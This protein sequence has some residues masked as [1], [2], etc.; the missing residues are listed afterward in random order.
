MKGRMPHKLRG[1]KSQSY[2]R[3]CVFVDT[4]TTGKKL[5]SS[6]TEQV[7][8]L[9]V[10]QFR[11]YRYKKP[12]EQLIF[13]DLQTYWNWMISKAKPGER[14]YCVA[15]NQDF[16]F[17]ILKGLTF[18]SE[19]KFYM[20]TMIWESGR[21]IVI[22]SENPP[23]FLREKY[24]DNYTYKKHARTIVFI[25]TLNFFKMSLKQLGQIIG[26][27]KQEIN[28]SEC[29]EDQLIEYCIQDVNVLRTAFENYINYLENHDFGNFGLTIAKQAFNCF[30]H[31]Y[32]HSDLYVHTNPKAINLERQA[33]YGGR[34]ECFQIGKIEGDTYYKLDI[35]SMYPYVMKNYQYPTKL[36]LR[37]YI[38]DQE[39]LHNWMKNY[40]V[41]ANVSFKTDINA[42][43]YRGKNKLLF[44]IGHITT[45]LCQPELELLH[46]YN[47]SYK[48]NEI[49]VY[50]KDSIFTQFVDG[51]YNLRL[52]SKKQSNRQYEQ[53]TK[54]IMNSLYGKFGQRTPNWD[55]TNYTNTKESWYKNIVDA[56]TGKN[57]T[58]KSVGGVVFTFDGWKEGYDTMVAIPA[59][60]TSYARVMLWNLIE[61]AGIDNVYYCDTDSLFVNNEGLENL[62]SS[63]DA[64]KLGYLKIEDECSQFEIH[65]VK[66]YI[67]N[68][69]IKI[70]GVSKKAV[71]V[72]E[73]RYKVEHWEHLN[74]AVHKDR[75][76]SVVIIDSEKVLKRQYEKGSIQEN[77]RILPYY[78]LP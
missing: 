43:P 55:I 75:A 20:Q 50:K 40:L 44:P 10:A 73:N 42:F 70:K 57:T 74:G 23:K 53:F 13:R 33:Y 41:I 77:K 65:N 38:V 78:I 45:S 21:F 72:S 28:L 54:I 1:N 22:Y 26:E 63:I 66:D 69:E 11:D 39:K 59:F 68:D 61:D 25:D 67:F 62:H 60:V 14:L 37:R 76:E 9:G 24:P 5:T 2:P 30:R 71:K 15:H 36:E 6:E 35:N 7:F 12:V 64:N 29:S 17:R 58:M 49:A 19:C 56:E 31:K 16:D 4:E 46:K 34:V 47:I 18:M 8:N 27:Y 48:I 51:L 32:L 3:L 52:Q